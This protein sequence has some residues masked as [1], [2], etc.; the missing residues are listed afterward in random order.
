MRGGGGGGGGGRRKNL[1]IN[2]TK[3]NKKREREN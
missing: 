3:Q 2:V 1:D